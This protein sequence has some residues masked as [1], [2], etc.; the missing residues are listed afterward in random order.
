MDLLP[1]LRKLEMEFEDFFETLEDFFS[2]G[3]DKYNAYSP[4]QEDFNADLTM[5]NGFTGMNEIDEAVQEAEAIEQ[6]LE[7]EGETSPHPNPNKYRKLGFFY[8][9]FEI[10][11]VPAHALGYGVL[12]R[13]F[14]Y[15]S[16][17][18]IRNDLYGDEFNEVLTHELTHMANPH[19]SELD[20]R[21][22][23]RQKLLFTPKW[24]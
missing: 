6:K 9:G 18:E 12:G 13:C 20:V 17:I 19:W 21:I 5:E 10:R 11:R 22:A 8:P 24:H 3:F 16:I 1:S 2:P 14:P 7:D 15:S 23:T 4:F